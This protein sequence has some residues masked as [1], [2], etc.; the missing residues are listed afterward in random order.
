MINGA[1][2]T[3]RIPKN[4]KPPFPILSFFFFSLQ[5]KYSGYPSK[6]GAERWSFNGPLP[7]FSHP[8]T[9]K[10]VKCGVNLDGLFT[11]DKGMCTKIK[12]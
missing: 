5:S 9:C 1:P 6:G 10:Y 2:L 11:I 7:T 12:P 3:N 8:K 4:S